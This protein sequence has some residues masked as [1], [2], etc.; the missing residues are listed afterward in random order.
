MALKSTFYCISEFK[1]KFT[2]FVQCFSQDNEQ[3]QFNG[4]SY[5]FIRTFLE[6]ISLKVPLLSVV[7][8][9]SDKSKSFKLVAPA[10]KMENKLY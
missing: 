1:A 9:L 3:L 6:S 4:F 10:K 2:W 8:L 5:R 7:S